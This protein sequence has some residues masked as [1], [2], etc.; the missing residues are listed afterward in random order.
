MIRIFQPVPLAV[1]TIVQLDINASHHVKG[2]LRATYHEPI[3]LFNGEGG[4]YEGKIVSI[5]KK[6]VKVHLEQY[7]ANDIESPLDLCLLQGISRGE[8]MDYTLQKATELGVKK[9]VPLMTARSTV[10]LDASRWK[11]K[12][13]HWRSILVSAC[14]QSGR[15]RLP[16]MTAPAS[17]ETGLKGIHAEWRFVLSPH[18]TPTLLS[19]FS[20][21]PEKGVAL[22]IGPEGGFCEEE[23]E[24]SVQYH[25]LPLH[26]GPRVLRTEKAALA[27]ITAFQCWFGDMV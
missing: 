22:L 13:D 8:K 20:I 5:D 6:H 21:Q 7:F 2:V 4:E 11:K 23:M 27:A 24:L 1:D 14:E 16:E 18:A 12:E 15:N 25:F 9:I 26:L 17:F 19:D 10:K 3:C